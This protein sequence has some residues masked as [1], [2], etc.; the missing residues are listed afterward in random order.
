MTEH[1]FRVEASSSG[2]RRVDLIGELDLAASPELSSVL[3]GYV[4]A[5]GDLTVDLSGVT[6]LDSTALSV[7]V[8]ARTR[9]SSAGSR[10]IVSDPSPVVVR[11]LHLAG[12]VGL[13]VVE[14]AE[15]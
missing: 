13:F 8:R 7:L 1:A 5:G 11:I 12:L 3:D 9:L 2:V 10:L 4:A 14:R 15:P 6:F